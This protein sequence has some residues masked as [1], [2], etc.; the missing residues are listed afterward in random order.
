MALS[1]YLCNL[2]VTNWCF[3]LNRAVHDGLLVSKVLL[4]TGQENRSSDVGKLDL[5]S[6]SILLKV[7]AL[8]T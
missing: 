4:H 8:S 7:T 5:D 2:S 1:C 6:V 3:V